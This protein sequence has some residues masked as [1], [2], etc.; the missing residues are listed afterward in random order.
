MSA[1]ETTANSKKTG[2]L[3]GVRNV[4][5]SG[6]ADG[7]WFRLRMRV[8]A[9]RVRIW[10]N[11]F[12]T[13][14]YL[15]PADP[16]RGEEHAGKRLSH[17]TFALQAHDP[18]S[19]VACRS[20]RMRPLPADADPELAGR[21]SDAGYGIDAMT[22]DQ[23]SARSIP[24]I[25]YHI[26][27]R[28]GLTPAKALD[29]QAVTGLQSGVLDNIGK[30]WSIETDEQLRAFLEQVKGVPMYVG[31][32]V[33]DRDWMNRH[34]PALLAQLDYVLADTMIMPMPDDNGP[35]VK[36]WLADQYKI[37]DPEAWMERYVRHNLRV[38]AEPITILANP[39]F[40]PP[41]LEDKYDQLWTD[42]R[43][44][45]VIQAALD[46]HVALEINASSPWPHERFIRM[47]KRMGAK[48]TFGSNNFDDKPINMSRCV[49]AIDRYGLKP[50]DLFVK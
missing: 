14:D 21:A 15:Q 34:S 27:L 19:V 24:L 38:L 4:F 49:E 8:V 18:G 29:R 35:P 13:V 36:L 6:V 20:I 28:G 48:F 17:G 31:M 37:D 39:T 25:D 23:L 43:M 5:K 16:P 22:M 10:V 47:A 11:D 7:Q 40:L 12:P 30:G 9:H 33:N 2:S 1:R 26:H 50:D 42:E 41:G 3:Y 45:Q 46:N 44:Q 32:Q